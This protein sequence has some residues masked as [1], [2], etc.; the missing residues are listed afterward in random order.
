MK[1]KLKEKYSLNSLIGK[2]SAMQKVFNLVS[3]VAP[4]SSNVL[5]LGESGTGKELIA[6]A[7][8]Y[9]SLRKDRQL[10]VVDCSALPEG[11]L[12]S[13]LF[14]HEKRAFTGA[15]NKKMGRIELA[16]GGTLFL[17]EIGEMT[18]KIQAKLLRVLQEKQFV[19]VGGL[20]PIKVD[21]RLIASTNR[22]L[23]KEV[24]EANFRADLY[25]RLNVITVKMPPL[26]EKKEDIP[27]LIDFFLE[28]YC[29]KE[30]RKIKSIMPEVMQSL[31]N[32]DWPGNVRE[33][34][35]CIERLVIVCQSDSIS[36]EYLTEELI[37]KD[38]CKKAFIIPDENY[39]L[40]EIEKTV[41]QRTLEK[42]SWNKSLA[43]KLLNINR[44][45]LY[46]R[47]EKYNIARSYPKKA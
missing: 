1:E 5:I 18:P 6:R 10:V 29:N 44:K 42:T 11:L 32:Y 30:K 4:S 35:N 36:P 15:T 33:L 46:N 47:I 7:L 25:Y 39:D 17:D 21:F 27:L 13:E 31:I 34:E 20:K 2:S 3:T 43:A 38:Y 45:A 28:K 37:E 9:G 23:K 40:Q 24:A 19:R 26:R 41:I 16:D 8:Y 14:G 22:D 12:Q